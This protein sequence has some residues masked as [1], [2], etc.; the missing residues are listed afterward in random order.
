VWGKRRT[1]LK[2]VE[3]ELQA[4]RDLRTRALSEPDATLQPEED[5]GVVSPKQPSDSPPSPEAMEL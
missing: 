1:E 4:I 2:K 3:A 5:E